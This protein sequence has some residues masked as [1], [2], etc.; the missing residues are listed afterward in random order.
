MLQHPRLH[1]SMVTNDKNEGLQ[2]LPTAVHAD[3]PDS[4]RTCLKQA[5]DIL[6]GEMTRLP[7]SRLCNHL[8]THQGDS[9]TP[10]EHHSVVTA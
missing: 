1:T 9:S 3:T 4:R 10:V 8:T 5:F 2:L 7:T 6:L